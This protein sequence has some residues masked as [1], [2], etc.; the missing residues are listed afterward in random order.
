MFEAVTNIQ[1][2]CGN[3]Q[4]KHFL[5]RSMCAALYRSL[6]SMRNKFAGTA[7][8]FFDCIGGIQIYNTNIVPTMIN[9]IFTLLALPL[10]L[11]YSTLF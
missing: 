2:M 4:T 8:I 10:V 9:F 7:W 6:V 11:L 5:K 3:W 1:L